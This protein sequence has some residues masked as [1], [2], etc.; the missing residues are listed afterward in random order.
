MLKDL[1]RR[2]RSYR[3]FDGSLSLERE[4]LLK[5]VGLARDC[6]SAANRQPLKFFLSWKKE[7]NE[8]LFPM[9]KWAGYLKDW[10]GPGEG[11][12]PSAYIVIAGD[13]EIAENFWCDHGIAS[14]AILLG[15]VEMGYG[16]CIIGAFDKNGLRS[17]FKISERFDLLLVL[18]LGRPVERVVLEKIP[19][20]GDIRYWRDEEGV[21]HVPKRDIEDMA[22]DLALSTPFSS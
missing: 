16:G 12:R 6:P 2:C 1:I 7:T 20:D 4:D 18:A 13:T 15:A 22:V 3:I 10:D 5:L 9:L 19:P 8:A 21:H 14:I 11:E 17:R